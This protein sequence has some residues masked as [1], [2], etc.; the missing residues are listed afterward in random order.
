MEKLNMR[1]TFYDALTGLPKLNIFKNKII[2]LI[3]HRTGKQNAGLDK[4][5]IA[6]IDIDNFKYL[7]DTLGSKASDEVI[8]CVANYLIDISKDSYF[9][10]RTAIDKFAIIFTE[11]KSNI[12]LLETIEE[13]INNVCNTTS[14]NNVFYITMSA[15]IALYPDHGRDINSLMQNTETALY[16]AK[17]AGKDIKIYSDKLQNDITDH[18][19]MVNKLQTGLEKGEFTLF[20]QPE[21]NLETNEIIGVEALVRWF[22]PANGYISPELFI[23]IAEKS[24]QIYALE[25]WIVNAALQQK[26]QWETDGLGHIE[27]SINLSSKTLESESNFQKIV[28]IFSSYKVNYSKIIIEVTETIIITNVDLAM[29]R[30]NRLRKLG[31]KIALDDFGTGY[32]SLTHLM[33]LPIDIIKIDRSFIK[34]IPY[35]SEETAIT[36]NVLSMAHDLNFRVVAEGIETMEQLEYLKTISCERGQGFLLCIPLP[37]EKVVEVLRAKYL[38]Y[39]VCDNG[40][41]Q[42]L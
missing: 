29:E 28:K 8:K 11:V 38:K 34:S 42:N 17:K 40:I 31:V 7:K 21:Y 3:K 33:K 2:D 14:T 19:Q 1:L 6:Y 41:S 39:I 18:V 32:S 16:S 20:Y 12:E 23:P 15:G 27:L 24:K 4:F 5:A 26:K 13:I 10:A 37:P 22:H 36:K 9:V 25:R 35:G 30:L